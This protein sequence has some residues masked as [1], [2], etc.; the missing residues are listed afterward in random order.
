[1]TFML[2]TLDY[3]CFIKFDVMKKYDRV[4]VMFHAFLT[5]L[6]GT[7]EWPASG[8][9]RFTSEE[10]DHQN[11]CSFSDERQNLLMLGLRTRPSSP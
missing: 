4:Q 5:P 8:L 2:Q 1:M 10:N 6:T 3:V 9:I 7:G 11:F